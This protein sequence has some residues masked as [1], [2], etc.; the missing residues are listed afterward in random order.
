M[1]AAMNDTVE[2]YPSERLAFCTTRLECTTPGGGSS[3]GTGFFFALPRADG[4]VTILVTNKHVIE[5]ATSVRFDLTRTSAGGAPRIGKTVEI[6]AMEEGLEWVNHPDS[7]VDLCALPMD[8]VVQTLTKQG[9]APFYVALA[10]DLIPTPDEIA[11][12]T[13]LEPIIMV[14]YPIGLSDEVNRMPV[15]RQGVTATD[16]RLNYQGNKEFLI[17]AACFPGSSGSPV[18]PVVSMLRTPATAKP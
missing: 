7:S 4:Q 5:D 14:G 15:F 10:A 9:S 13:A 12:V 8:S 1:L 11:L 16:P 3:F 17:D 2:L 18:C 6:D